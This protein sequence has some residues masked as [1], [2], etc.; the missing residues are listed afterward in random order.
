MPPDAPTEP[1]LSL[2]NDLDGTLDGVTDLHCIGGF[3]V[4]QAYGLDRAT[5]DIDVI[6]AL[7]RASSRSRGSRSRADQTRTEF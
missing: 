3:D 5:A 6:S 2:L 1:W 4:M 7:P